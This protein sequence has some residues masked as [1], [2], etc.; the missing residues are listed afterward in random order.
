MNKNKNVA[1]MFRKGRESDSFH[2]K[3]PAVALLQI[4][5]VHRF[6]KL[7]LSIRVYS[8]NNLRENIWLELRA[9]P[10]DMPLV[11][12]NCMWDF[13]QLLN[14][15]IITEMPRHVDICIYHNSQRRTNYRN[16]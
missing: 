3:I 12:Q 1:G 16:L 8:S 7:T 4:S 9:R 13:Y 5:N 10:C 6:I 14:S 11:N 15:V 2:I